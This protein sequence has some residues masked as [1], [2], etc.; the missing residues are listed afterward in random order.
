MDNEEENFPDISFSDENDIHEHHSHNNQV[1]AVIDFSSSNNKIK[2]ITT[3][4]SNHLEQRYF[5]KCNVFTKIEWNQRNIGKNST[6]I[7]KLDII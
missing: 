4:F 7:F 3:I 2:I 1:S 5:K 6:N